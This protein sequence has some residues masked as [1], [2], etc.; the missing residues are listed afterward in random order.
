ML[1]NILYYSVCI[2][3]YMMSKYLQVVW[4]YVTGLIVIL[5]GVYLLMLESGPSSFI[6]MLIGLAI[7]AI[8]SAHGR[9]MRQM[10]T[11]DIEEL[12]KEGGEP[13]PP[14]T[15]AVEQQATEQMEQQIGPEQPPQPAPAQPAEQ[16]E[17]VPGPIKGVVGPEEQE[18]AEP[19]KGG[20]LGIFNKEPGEPDDR[21]LGHDDVMEIELEDIRSGKLVPTEA[22]VIELVCPKCGAENNEKNFYCYSCGMKLR[23]KPGKDAKVQ[24]PKITVEPG[25]ISLVGEQRVAKVIICPKCNAANKEHDKFCFNCGK[26]LRSDKALQKARRKTK[27]KPKK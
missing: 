10:G 4:L 18:P 23:R 19:K 20:I 3:F 8:G 27:P 2:I 11:F 15:P 12:M 17:E 21:H 25:S 16:E 1:H 7:A 26:K 22:D 6:V 5:L 14:G 13:L 24:E 9:K